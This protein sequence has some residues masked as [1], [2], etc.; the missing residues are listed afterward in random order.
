M[1]RLP[2]TFS[3]PLSHN[4]N[5]LPSLLGQFFFLYFRIQSVSKASLLQPQSPLL[6][7]IILVSLQQERTPSP[8]LT[9]CP[10]QL[11]YPI[12]L[13]PFIAITPQEMAMPNLSYPFLSWTYSHLLCVLP[14]PRSGSC[15][16]HQWHRSCQIYGRSL[17][18]SFDSWMLQWDWRTFCV[19]YQHT[20][21]S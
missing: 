5:V 8:S 3:L 18:P 15:P 6:P 1:A 12:F 9:R 10:L 21:L 11:V 2:Q 16:L 4:E 13:L 7:Y 14:I 20:A 17:L 19:G